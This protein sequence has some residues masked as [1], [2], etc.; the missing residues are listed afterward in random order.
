[1]EARYTPAPASVHRHG[2]QPWRV[3]ADE[4]RE[5]D[6]RRDVNHAAEITVAAY[7]RM[8]PTTLVT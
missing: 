6:A 3:R 2:E 5:A 7:L 8:L 1:M 4:N